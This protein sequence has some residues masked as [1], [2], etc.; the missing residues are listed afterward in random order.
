MWYQKKL[1]TIL[2]SRNI[3]IKEVFEFNYGRD[4]LIKRFREAYKPLKR[5]IESKKE[6]ACV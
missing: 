6:K 4:Y 1:L 5:K 3:F 2:Q